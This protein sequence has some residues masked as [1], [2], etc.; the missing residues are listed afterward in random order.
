MLQI[1]TTDKAIKVVKDGQLV[2]IK[3]KG[4]IWYNYT[5]NGVYL[6]PFSDKDDFITETWANGVTLDGADITPGNVEEKFEDFF[7][8]SGGGGTAAVWGQITGTLSDQTDLNDTLTGIQED[9]DGL[10]AIITGGT[11]G[12]VLTS[13]GTGSTPVWQTQSV[14]MPNGSVNDTYQDQPVD[15]YYCVAKITSDPRPEGSFWYKDMFRFDFIIANQAA[16][17][18]GYSAIGNVSVYAGQWPNDAQVINKVVSVGTLE[19]GNL[20]I[21]QEEV[22]EN[23]AKRVVYKIWMRKYI[24]QTHD[25]NICFL[26]VSNI[27]YYSGEGGMVD[28]LIEYFKPTA[29]DEFIGTLPSQTEASTPI[30]EISF[31]GNVNQDLEVPGGQQ[32]EA[33]N[34]QNDSLRLM[35]VSQDWL[36]GNSETKIGQI[37]LVDYGGGEAIIWD[38]QNGWNP[39]FDFLYADTD[40]EYYVAWDTVTKT[41]TFTPGD[42][43]TNVSPDIGVL[44]GMLWVNGSPGESVEV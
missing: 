37:S 27:L 4:K 6:Y 32:L 18:N 36:E 30:E 3:Q 42:V 19:S 22:P 12:Q 21:T 20:Y 31:N 15:R 8:T 34:I 43:V 33:I 41:I 25:S 35:V 14:E 39:D 11:A 2:A 24:T 9:T 16:D 7:L 28:Y 23:G 5:V 10:T 17:I 38:Y 29:P 26:Q 13:S 1:T 40:K 44:D